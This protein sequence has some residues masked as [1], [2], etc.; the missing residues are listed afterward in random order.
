MTLLLGPSETIPNIS[1]WGPPQKSLFW[2]AAEDV[3]TAPGVLSFFLSSFE[4]LLKGTLSRNGH[5]DPVKPPFGLAEKRA[6][7]LT[8]GCLKF[9]FSLDIIALKKEDRF[10][11]KHV[12]SSK[13]CFC[14]FVFFWCTECQEL[15]MQNCGFLRMFAATP[16]YV[17]SFGVSGPFRLGRERQ[18]EH[19]PP[20][21]QFCA[22]VL[23]I[24]VIIWQNWTNMKKKGH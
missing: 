13:I 8:E 11:W 4:F 14:S 20:K 15:S 16:L 22:L 24:S 9:V 6:A 17:S 12:K 18:R 7:A 10:C 5:L 3:K 21:K 1:S 23:S 19:P 2:T